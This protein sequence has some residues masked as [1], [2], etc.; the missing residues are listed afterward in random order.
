MSWKWL[1]VDNP[2][3]VPKPWA[4]ERHPTGDARSD[5]PLG[6]RECG[7]GGGRA[8][9][10]VEETVVTSWLPA[11]GTGTE[12]RA[13]PQWPSSRKPRR[14]GPQGPTRKKKPKS[15]READSGDHGRTQRGA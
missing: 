9:R 10:V 14:Q 2:T 3:P 5:G 12:T 1:L 11:V 4:S 8:V 13:R 7:L 15:S 6:V